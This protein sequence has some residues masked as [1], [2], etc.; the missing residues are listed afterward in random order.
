MRAPGLLGSLGAT[1]D[2]NVIV[3]A[4][5]A[6]KPPPECSQCG[7]ELVNSDRGE[8]GWRCENRCLDGGE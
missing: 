4:S 1:L 8:G 3:R 6:S 7:A 5:L 2:Q